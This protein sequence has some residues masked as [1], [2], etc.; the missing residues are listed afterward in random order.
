MGIAATRKSRDQSQPDLFGKV[1]PP[2]ASRAQPFDLQK[3][4][5]VALGIWRVSDDP[6]DAAIAG[7]WFTSHGL[8]L[9]ADIA[10]SVVRYHG[11]LKFGDSRAPGL[12]FLMRDIFTD[13]PCSV[14]RV[15]MNERG[16]T[17]GR[18][19][20]GRAFNTAIK[21]DA[22]DGAV[23]LTSSVEAGIRALNNGQ[24]PIWI[25]SA[26]SLNEIVWSL[27]DAGREVVRPP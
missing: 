8:E 4:T 6:R 2:R 26:N 21:L 25:A 14:L 7:R 1:A 13:A 22:S 18:K 11:S 10:C 5:M 20:L 15:F 3:L 12:V 27:R 17:V 24:R 9:T 16:E 23:H 19:I